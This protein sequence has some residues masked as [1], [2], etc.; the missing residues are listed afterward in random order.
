MARPATSEASMSAVPLTELTI[1]SK[2]DFSPLIRTASLS[3]RRR[4][5]MA[6]IFHLPGFA[7]LP[8]LGRERES[9]VPHQ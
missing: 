6:F 7:G 2:V 1:W 3:G 4:L 8:L 9:S 5:A